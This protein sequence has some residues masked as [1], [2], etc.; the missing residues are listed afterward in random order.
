MVKSIRPASGTYI[1][2]QMAGW[3]QRQ[4]RVVTITTDV[5]RAPQTGAARV[6]PRTR[7]DG[8]IIAPFNLPKDYKLPYNF[9]KIGYMLVPGIPGTKPERVTIH[10]GETDPAIVLLENN[11]YL[12]GKLYGTKHEK[13]EE[14]KETFFKRLAFFN[15]AA[16]ILLREA[17]IDLPILH[18]FDWPAALSLLYLEEENFPVPATLFTYPNA[19]Y[20]GNYDSQY[21]R[22]LGLTGKRPRDLQYYSGISFAQA[23]MIKADLVLTSWRGHLRDVINGV[24]REGGDWG[25]F[26]RLFAER[27]E[28]NRLFYLYRDFKTFDRAANIDTLSPRAEELDDVFSTL[29]RYDD[30]YLRLVPQVDVSRVPEIFLYEAAENGMDFSVYSR[31]AR[32]L[33]KEI[34]PDEQPAFKALIKGFRSRRAIDIL[35][36]GTKSEKSA[37]RASLRDLSKNWYDYYKIARRAL[38]GKPRV[39]EDLRAVITHPVLDSPENIKETGLQALRGEEN[40][41]YSDLFVVTM[42]GGLGQRLCFNIQISQ[43]IVVDESELEEKDIQNLKQIEKSKKI[44]MRYQKAGKVYWYIPAVIMDQIELLSKIKASP[45]TFIKIP[46][47]ILGEETSKILKR[48][49]ITQLEDSKMDEALIIPSDLFVS[50]STKLIKASNKFE[51]LLL[52]EVIRQMIRDKKLTFINIP[53]GIYKLPGADES[54]FEMQARSLASLGQKIGKKPRWGI[55]LSNDNQ[56]AVRLFFEANLDKDGLY[57]GLL[58]K[59]QVYFGNQGNNPVVEITDEEEQEFDIIIDESSGKIVS[60]G[61]G[62]GGLHDVAARMLKDLDP[63]PKYILACNIENVLINLQLGNPDFLAGWLGQHLSDNFE[64]TGLSSKKAKPDEEMGV[65]ALG[66]RVERVVEYNHPSF[67]AREAFA[68]LLSSGKRV[69]FAKD[70]EERYLLINEKALPRIFKEDHPPGKANLSEEIKKLKPGYRLLGLHEIPK[71]QTLHLM[72]DFLK[73]TGEKKTLNDLGQTKLEYD[74]GNTNLFIFNQEFIRHVANNP[75]IMSA[76]EHK[77]G[78]HRQGFKI[79]SSIFAPLS[80][81]RLLEAQLESGE[82]RIGFVEENRENCFEPVKGPDDVTA[83][84]SALTN[85]KKKFPALF[86]PHSI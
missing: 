67:S 2:L 4:G 21:L 43:D 52:K 24:R 8:T 85:L 68:Y 79:E 36:L 50:L 80:L 27:R 47:Q 65:F 40:S 31:Y 72:D 3:W 57:F 61:N 37:F 30:A 73:F 23:G 77:K 39:F 46:S 18:V 9:I 11:A 5:C 64:V 38:F 82:I 75:T 83:V 29:L 20:Q 60:E 34:S 6:Q 86:G 54:L 44:L 28:S 13:G 76:E 55:M 15:R 10:V 42:S 35:D 51:H 53:K 66:D 14:T 45:K 84:I 81:V 71:K 32:I 16:V 7:P 70:P 26:Q 59:D 69:Y 19:R 48:K 63:A 33:E 49:G 58:K 62:H 41:P 25:G 22:L 12:A 74:Q 78:D 56:A 1:N 17:E